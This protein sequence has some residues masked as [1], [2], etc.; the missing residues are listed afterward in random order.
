MLLGLSIRVDTFNLA[1]GMVPSLASLGT[2][3]TAVMISTG[4]GYVVWEDWTHAHTHTHT[5]TH[6]A[7]RYSK[8]SFH[9][10]VSS[11]MAYSSLTLAI[12]PPLKIPF[13]V[14][15]SSKFTWGNGEFI[16]NS[17]STP[18]LNTNTHTYIHIYK[19]IHTHIQTHTYTYVNA[20]SKIQAF[21]ALFKCWEKAILV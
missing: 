2:K 11:W 7:S 16:Q 3:F 4:L 8:N 20:S 9:E 6:I 12:L 14:L 5:H 17:F 15:L 10:K 13:D 19:H 21:T 18:N 1:A